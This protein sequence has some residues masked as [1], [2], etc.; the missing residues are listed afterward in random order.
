MSKKQKMV[1]LV[2]L[3]LFWLSCLSV[4]WE[5]TEGLNH[6][7]TIKYSPIFKV[8]SGG[9]W[10]MRHPS[11]NVAYTWAALVI[12]WGL[13]VLIVSQSKKNGNPEQDG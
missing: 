12:S 11:T 8:P 2:F 5:L 6:R 13:I 10:Q 3:G 7:D 1:T 9:S 4:P